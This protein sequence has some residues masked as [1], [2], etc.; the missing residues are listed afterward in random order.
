MVLAAVLLQLGLHVGR[1]KIGEV[2]TRRSLISTAG[3]GSLAA[4]LPFAAHAEDEKQRRLPAAKL[5]ELVRADIEQN[6]F[7]VTG[8]LTRSLYDESCT[9]KDE[10]DTYTLDKWIKG[11]GALFVGEKSHVDIVGDV[12]ATEKEVRFRFSEVL[13]FNI[14][15][16]PKVPLTGTLVLTRGDDGLFTAYNEIWDTNVADT[17]RRGYL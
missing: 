10:I 5:A 12:A 7:L 17:L 9:F 8:K 4:V 15:L 14:P 16:T 2:C 6:Q 11:T 3:G 13:A 1:P